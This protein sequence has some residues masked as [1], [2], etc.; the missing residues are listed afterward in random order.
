M[1]TFKRCI[2]LLLVL[3]ILLS[4]LAPAAQAAP[5][6][7]TATVDTD[8]MTIKGTNGFGNLLRQEITESQE[9]A[10]AAGAE[11]PGG[12][13]VTDLVIEGTTATV[14]YDT[15]EEATLVVALYTEDGMQMLTS[16]TATVAPDATEAELTFEG[17]M[18]EYFLASAY[19]LDS[20]D[21]SPLCAAY[22]TPMYTRE[23]QELLASTVNDYDPEKVLN[24]DEDE[25]TNFAVYA[26]STIVIEAEEGINTV[27]SID[28]ENLTYVIKNANEQITS[29]VEGNVFVYPYAENEI[30]IAK[31]DTITVA[32]TTVTITSAE[33][34]MEE[35]FAYTKIEGQS[36]NAEISVD[37]STAGEGISY[38]GL[39]EDENGTL[40]PQNV[41]GGNTKKYYHKFELNIG[42]HADSGQTSASL[43]VTG[44]LELDLTVSLNYY[45]STSRR[46]I[47]FTTTSEINF[48]LGVHDELVLYEH[49]G[50]F[51]IPV[52]PGVKAG[53]EPELQLRF[54]GEM[55]LKVTLAAVVGFQYDNGSG[56]Q[57]LSQKPTID[58]K[59]DVEG[60]IFLGVDLCPQIELIDDSVA[61][62][63][64]NILVGV[65]L[66]AT[67]CGTMY[68]FYDSDSSE[69][70]LCRECL[71]LD[72]IFKV[73]IGGSLR[74]LEQDWLT[75]GITIGEVSYP[76]GSMYYSLDNKEFGFG[77]CPNKLFRVTVQVKDKEYHPIPGETV[78]V[79]SLEE[80]LTTDENGL[81]VFYTPEDEIV[82]R[83]EKDG[84]FDA[85]RVT[86]DKAQ[87][88]VL[89][90]IF[91]HESGGNG[92]ANDDSEP[93]NPFEGIDFGGVED[94]GF[95]DKSETVSS[96]TC[97]TNVQW[98]LYKNGILAIT[99]K[100]RMDDYS[101]A[102]KI[103]W[104][105]LRSD[106]IRVFVE[107]NITS[108][109]DYAFRDCKNLS[110]V[111]IPDSVT[112]I[113]NSAFSGCT[114]LWEMVIPN[115]VEIVGAA[116]FSECGN[117]SYAVIGTGVTQIPQY[118]FS[119]CE[120]LREIVIPATVNEIGKYALNDCDGLQTVYYGGTERVWN[121]MVV[122]RAGAD[123]NESLLN[124]KVIFG[125]ADS[126][127]FDGG[128]GS[129]DDPYLVSTAQ[130]L[131]AVHEDLDAHYVQTANI[132][133][134]DVIWEPIGYVHADG[135][136]VGIGDVCAFTGSYNGQNHVI[137][138][139]TITEIS[140][141]HRAVGLF[142]YNHGILRNIVLEDSMI[143]LEVSENTL[144][145]VMSGSQY[146]P[147]P[148]IGGI[149]GHSQGTV[150]DCSNSGIISVDIAYGDIVCVGGILGYGTG[151]RCTNDASI[152]ASGGNG[153]FGGAMMLRC[154]G[155]TGYPGAINEDVLYCVNYGDISCTINQYTS[156]NHLA[157]GGITGNHGELI[158][159]VNFGDVSG[160]INS[161]RNIS[162]YCCVG[163]LSGETN[164]GSGNYSGVMNC[165]NF[166]NVAAYNSTD[167]ISC[168]AG[169]LFGQFGGEATNCYNLGEW[170]YADLHLVTK[171]DE[172]ECKVGRIFGRGGGE[173]NGCYSLDT[174]VL[175]AGEP[176]Y[177]EGQGISMG[178]AEI[179]AAIEDILVTLDIPLDT[180]D[181]TVN[182]SEEK[183]SK[184]EPLSMRSEKKEK[185]VTPNAVFGG[186][187][188]V[189]LI[190][191]HILKTAAFSNLVPGEQYVMLAMVSVEGADPLAAEN[192]LG[193]AQ[194][195]ADE[196]GTLSFRYIQRIPYDISYVVVCGASSKNLNDAEIAF[197][198]MIADG[199]LQVV[200]PVVAYDGVT[201]T[202]GQDYVI[203]GKVDFTEAGEYTCYIRGIHNYAGLVECTYTV[204][205]HEHSFTN[206]VS[207]G[208][209]TC[210]EDGTKTAKCD[211]CDATD[212]IPDIGSALGHDMGSWETTVPATCTENGEEQRT[213]SRCDHSESRVIEAVG[214]RWD[215]GV[216]TREPTEDTE[217]ERL[218]TCTACG[219]TKTEPIPV[220]GHEHRYEAVVTAPTCTE[221]GYTT[222]TCKCG[223]SYV[224]DYV[225]ALGHSFGEWIV[226]QEPT[227]TEDGL[228][229]RSCS[230]C[231]HI[232]QRT[233]AKLENP[234]NDVA[235]GSFY[236]EP[237]MW[238]IENGIT[239][240]TSATTFGPNDQCMRAH[241]VTF[242]WR[243]VGSPEPT[244][245]DNPFVDVKPGDFYYK[246]VLWAL[247]YG[248]TSG[249]DAIHFG[250]TS[251]CNRAQVVTFLYRT[252]GSPELES[253]EN[254]FTD[255]SKG[256]FYEK[257]VLWAVQNGITN[258]LSATTFGPNAI[259]NRA[260]IV[261]FLYRAFVN[262]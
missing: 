48:D 200:D 204:A 224:A 249:M 44:T 62:I 82:V 22:D 209:A 76:L 156:Q 230:R 191:S 251:Y 11:Y 25:T 53:F 228:E 210:T 58:L 201:L 55:D 188:G 213:C 247:E 246:P 109:C 93:G 78:T 261:T 84:Y 12:Y 23:M 56:F 21:L 119:G 218:Y 71:D 88:I 235:P 106:I 36:K 47:S 180:D 189:E 4:V 65:E 193:I 102:S 197:P 57:N 10:E 69:K 167:K 237:V 2:S 170:V 169:G 91:K 49:L 183:L 125:A 192:L 52:A 39:V 14:T 73:K 176:K 202:E 89:C 114:S 196:D 148:C 83:A 41:E 50:H 194:G 112:E 227:T 216:V 70:H 262:D 32:G 153:D 28:D 79:S 217:G 13:T 187:Y 94:N 257:P 215:K 17:E 212:T 85:T 199:E 260:Q 34:E 98:C 150:L 5:A 103:P 146:Y 40:G 240:G 231:G 221:R 129:E 141:L 185:N 229:E 135:T 26:D 42:S 43:S 128:I 27:A 232:E 6:E 164:A 214:H 24:L 133:L 130:Q 37:D 122:R 104:N 19:L 90:L 147:Y 198:N 243:A 59:M 31:I 161:N 123:H 29:L 255:V 151:S 238:A 154:G 244:R 259:C 74:F 3:G 179:Y 72:A 186:E 132:D 222:Y 140:D 38:V 173:L 165:V 121:K 126:V 220:I 105:H 100:G 250:P 86:A 87:K 172:Y 234:F 9:E 155:I 54:E 195:I 7:E 1:S 33:L 120:Q 226:I 241:V 182:K 16:A 239:N 137:K 8:A 99:G 138:N 80:A 258:G 107:G 20:Y 63:E 67:A 242:L 92:D 253:A 30:L 143:I 18:P 61:E 177:S 96:G 236:Y 184:L 118:L 166:G 95:V 207:D 46:Y 75:V 223:E 158:Y 208:N 51:S 145:D 211:H 174:T 203:A 142:G 157:C 254:P 152:Q 15:M 178:E 97:G 131:Q 144:D 136:S 113:G 149:V 171:P 190:D 117:L 225:D 219:A 115:G 160:K 124:A 35:V 116:A 101:S 66:K 205:E 81:V 64:A 245:T 111:S 181:Q 175:G 60:S 252:M 139:M 163:G 45:L 108:I 77:A 134:C 110:E 233:V 159:C 248:I 162:E 168:C 127:K 206:Y 68:E 256:S